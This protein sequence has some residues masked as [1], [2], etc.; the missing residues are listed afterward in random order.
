MRKDAGSRYTRQACVH[1]FAGGVVGA[2]W[3]A[4]AIGE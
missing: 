4:N 2:S 1:A 3:G